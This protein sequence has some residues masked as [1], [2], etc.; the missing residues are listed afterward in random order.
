[1]GLALAPVTGGG[2]L[3]GN[4]VSGSGSGSGSDSGSGCW[5]AQAVYGE[6]DIRTH[7][8]R[9]WLNAEYARTRVGGAVMALYR[10]VGRQ[11]APLVRGPVRWML[12]PLFDVALRKAL[13]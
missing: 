6:H 9:C 7:M 3:F 8:V 13:A 4:L 5:I 12:K 10:M 1:M 11:V 2:S